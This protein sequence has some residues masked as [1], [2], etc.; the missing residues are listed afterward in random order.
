MKILPALFGAIVATSQLRRSC[1]TQGR[2]IVFSPEWRE[3][4]EES[5]RAHE[6]GSKILDPKTLRRYHALIRK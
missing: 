5:I 2:A 4:L 3:K 1:G 6:D